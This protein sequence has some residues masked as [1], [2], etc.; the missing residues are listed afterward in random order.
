MHYVV[1]SDNAEDDRNIPMTIEHY[2]VLWH[3]SILLVRSNQIFD[4]I[5]DI[6]KGEF[7]NPDKLH[8][9]YQKLPYSNEIVHFMVQYAFASLK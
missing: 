6:H 3:L 5:E 1:L 4:A 8:Q 9:V 7:L 2:V